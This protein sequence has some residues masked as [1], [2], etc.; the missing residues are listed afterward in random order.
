VGRARERCG[1]GGGG[2]RRTAGRH[3]GHPQPGSGSSSRVA[4]RVAR[5]SAGAV[6][7]TPRGCPAV[8]YGCAVRYHRRAL[9]GG[10]SLRHREPANAR[11]PAL[12]AS[13]SPVRR[14]VQSHP[15]RN[16]EREDP[17]GNRGEQ[18]GSHTGNEGGAGSRY[19]SGAIKEE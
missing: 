12:G 18:E 14:C 17:G 4:V 19:T 8:P 15:C 10:R 1:R 6:R 9:P 3:A 16:R 7:R 13:S 11:T 2:L 5:C